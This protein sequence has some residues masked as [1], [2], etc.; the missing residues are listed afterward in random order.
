[1]IGIIFACAGMSTFLGMIAVTEISRLAR[2]IIAEA[3]A[4]V[5]EHDTDVFPDHFEH[6]FPNYPRP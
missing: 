4:C 3:T 1:M 5:M 2:K 6:P